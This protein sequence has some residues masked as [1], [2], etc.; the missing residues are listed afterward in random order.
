MGLLIVIKNKAIELSL[1]KDVLS[2]V[3][4][5]HS[6]DM[7]SPYALDHGGVKNLLTSSLNYQTTQFFALYQI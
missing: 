3:Y 5:E 1:V 7:S 6:R 4:I 2:R